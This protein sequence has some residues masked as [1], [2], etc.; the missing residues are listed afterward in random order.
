MSIRFKKRKKTR[1]PRLEQLEKRE[2][3]AANTLVQLEG[4]TLK[5]RGTSG[6]DE[7]TVVQRPEGRFRGGGGR[8]YQ[9]STGFIGRGVTRSYIFPAT[10]VTN[11]D[12]VMGD[13]S[14]RFRLKSFYG[15]NSLNRV[16]VDLGFSNRRTPQIVEVSNTDLAI[17]QITG[18]SS[19]VTKTS[20]LIQNSDITR[21]LNLKLGKSQGTDRVR[22]D[23]SEVNRL[24]C[25]TG[26]G[27]DHLTIS[28]S[29][30]GNLKG[31]LGAGN[32]RFISYRSTVDS[33]KL[34][35]GT[36]WD[37]VDGSSLKSTNISFCNFESG[38][39]RR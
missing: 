39:N 14:D 3:L 31:N 16:N 5:I 2:L 1:R 28:R 6:N 22:I 17:L 25:K 36:G 20:V 37:R 8:V 9:V 24:I 19:S 4:S 30:V 11:I 29:H 27:K 18:K 7:V 12:A 10:S 26:K 33:G 21:T 23:G 13:G 35:G 15:R 32:D 34:K 38:R